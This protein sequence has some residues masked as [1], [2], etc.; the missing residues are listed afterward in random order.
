MNR[1]PSAP[2][3]NRPPRKVI[4]GSVIC[5][6]NHCPD[7]LEGHLER[8]DGLIDEVARRARAAYLGRDCDLIVLPEHAI[9]TGAADKAAAAQAVDLEG[10]VLARLGAAARRARS[11]LIVPVIRATDRAA[12]VF[13]NTAL[14][15][16]RAGALVGHYDKYHTV[17]PNGGDVVE[18]GMTPGNA[19]PVFDLDFGRIGIQICF[20][21]VFEDGWAAL[22]AQGAE[23]VAWPSMS[24]CTILPRC[25]AQEHG[26]YLLGSNDSGNATLYTPGGFI[27]AQ[28]RGKEGF[29]IEEIDLS[30]MLFHWSFPLRN[31]AA[32]DDRFPGE[33]GYRYDAIEDLGLFWSNNPE[34]SIGAMA[35]E[36]G[37]E[38]LPEWLDRN[39]QATA[40]IRPPP[41]AA[42]PPGAGGTG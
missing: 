33:V 27:G 20:D 2:R 19:F 36:L 39:A 12:G 34:R 6:Y 17:L 22:A 9:R 24:A 10:P 13:H 40:A 4:V 42:F 31:G 37:L 38:A 25:R 26:Y 32:F 18:R 41:D 23:L 28:V 15:F 1:D 35:A 11:N 30:W 7:S 8:A 3:A 16:D 29:L 14:L 21:I 5:S